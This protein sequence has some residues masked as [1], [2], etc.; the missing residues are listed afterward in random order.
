MPASN[1]PSD[2]TARLAW[3]VDR[4]AI[5]DL[6]GN[7]AISIDDKDKAGY[8]A[9][10]VEDAVLE[11]PFGTII[12]KAAIAEMPGPP[13]EWGTQHL[14]GE[15]IIDLHGDEATTRAYMM[16]THVFDADDR[17][18]KAHSGGWY[19]HR[20]VRTPDGWRLAHVRLVVVWEDERPMLP[21]GPATLLPPRA[22]HSH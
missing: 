5:R 3:L 12:G 22:E 20:A 8:A 2:P 13:Q 19:Q 14:I 1:P 11:L 9:N 6:I 10:F 15:V 18:R 16:A 7:F 21:D 4:E 17:S